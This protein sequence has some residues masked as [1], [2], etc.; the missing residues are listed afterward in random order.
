MPPEPDRYLRVDDARAYIEKTIGND[1]KIYW[2]DVQEFIED[3]AANARRDLPE[4]FVKA[5]SAKTA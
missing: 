4:L 2:G 5:E 1:L 3:F